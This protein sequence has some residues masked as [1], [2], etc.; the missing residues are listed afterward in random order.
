MNLIVKTLK[1]TINSNNSG[2]QEK[3][4]EISLENFIIIR[5][6]KRSH[7]KYTHHRTNLGINHQYVEI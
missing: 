6:I 7:E 5:K 2:P 3:Y 1:L 4:P